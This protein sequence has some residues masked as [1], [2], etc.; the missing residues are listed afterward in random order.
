MVKLLELIRMKTYNFAMIYC[1]SQKL[2]FWGGGMLSW[3]IYVIGIIC[4]IAFFPPLLLQILYKLFV[5]KKLRLINSIK[6]S[7]LFFKYDKVGEQT[8]LLTKNKY[9]QSTEHIVK[10]WSEVHY[11]FTITWQKTSEIQTITIDF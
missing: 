11:H 3:V 8:I 7:K 1:V 9:S 4:V 2:R 6:L 5:S 10:L